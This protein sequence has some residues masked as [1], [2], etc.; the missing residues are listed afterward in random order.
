[1]AG[2]EYKSTLADTKTSPL[3]ARRRQTQLRFAQTVS[4]MSEEISDSSISNPTVGTTEGVTE[5]KR[6]KALLKTGA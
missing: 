1:M 4:P 3:G 6:Q 5:F 2:L